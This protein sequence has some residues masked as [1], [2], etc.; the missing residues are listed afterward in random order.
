LEPSGFADN[1][2]PAP[3][4]RKKSRPEV[5]DL[6]ASALIDV[7]AIELMLTISSL[8]FQSTHYAKCPYA[9]S[10]DVIRSSS[11]NESCVFNAV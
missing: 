7:E 9:R 3:R 4:S 6:L 11:E 5:V 2:R 8:S 10:A 1:T